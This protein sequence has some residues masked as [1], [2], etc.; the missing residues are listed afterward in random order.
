MQAKETGGTMNAMASGTQP[1][2]R[3]VVVVGV[4][5]YIHVKGSLMGTV[6]EEEE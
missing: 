1:D 6:S 3:L 2:Y 4:R 5:V